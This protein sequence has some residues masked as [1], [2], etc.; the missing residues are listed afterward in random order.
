MT[1]RS[2]GYRGRIDLKVCT[3]CGEPVDNTTRTTDHLIPESQGGI[4]SNDNR[5]PS[6]SRCNRMKGNMT[7]EE[8]KKF[9]ERVIELEYTFVKIKTGYFKRVAISCKN[10]IS[11]ST[12]RTI[13]IN[14]GEAKDS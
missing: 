8:F 7:V 11:Q 5:V 6:C 4:K 3:Y 9:L 14:N 12:P 13:E 1:K 2:Q 10:I